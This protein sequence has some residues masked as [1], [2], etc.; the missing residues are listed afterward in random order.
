M[1]DEQSPEIVAQVSSADSAPEPEASEDSAEQSAEAPADEQPAE[2]EVDPVEQAHAD[3]AAA[4]GLEPGADYAVEQNGVAVPF[5]GKLVG[6][7]DLGVLIRAW[8]GKLSS[9]HPWSSIRSLIHQ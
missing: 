4:H 3:H 2:P 8:G 6:T 9:F 1:A 5:V 7:N